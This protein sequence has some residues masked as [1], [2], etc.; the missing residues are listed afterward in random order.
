MSFLATKNNIL[1]LSTYEQYGGAAR[2]AYRLHKEF[3]NQH[4]PSTMLV[5]RKIEES[6]AYSLAQ[7]KNLYTKI[8][9]R[10]SLKLDRLP[11]K[12]TQYSSQSPWSINWFPNRIVPLIN[13]INPDIIHLHWVG[14]GFVPISALTKISKPLVWT[15]HDSWAFTGGCHIPFE[16]VGYRTGCGNCPQLNSKRQHD[17]SH[18]IWSKKQ[19]F[20]QDIPL[21]IVTPS[22]WLA[23]CA[24]SS[25]LFTQRTIKVIPNGIDLS[26]YRPI[27]KKLARE[28]LGLP[29]DKKIILFGSV[30]ATQ[31]K[32]KGFHLL[33]PALEILSHT[34]NANQYELAIFGAD[35][36]KG[37]PISSL[38]TYYLGYLH[39]DISLAV[40][41]SAADVFVAPSMSEN[42]PNTII[43]SFACSTPSVAFQIGGIP[44]LIDHQQNGYLATPFET[45]DLAKGIEW[46]L[47]DNERWIKLSRN[48]R[49][50]A[51]HEYDIKIIAQ[52]YANLYQEIL[53]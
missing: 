47:E 13:K 37:E 18:Q 16:C 21:T 33:Q 38:K 27:D 26:R 40:M 11:L 2:A 4:I 14:F 29:Q 45:D 12:L 39:D 10:F 15:F 50:K 24:Q 30:G 53:N 48:A 36:P 22:Y 7:S 8:S 52:R 31:D 1:I 34:K 41:Y 6:T 35:E 43:E 44:D 3:Q 51:T 28:L 25:S 5:N 49:Q 19:K 46:I 20:W 9:S 32:N 42:L 23:E 17:L